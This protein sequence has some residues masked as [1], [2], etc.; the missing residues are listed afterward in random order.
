[1][2]EIRR[3]AGLRHPYLVPIIDYGVS[4]DTVYIAMPRLL[5][6]SLQE[7]L[8][9][10]RMQQ[11]LRRNEPL[12]VAGLPSLGEIAA[13]L[14]RI[15]AGLDYAHARQI[16]HQQVQP[17]NI[18]FDREGHAYLGD[19]GLT[20][21]F[22]V[23]FSLKETN[24][25]T[26]H[27]FSS[28]EQWQGETMSA[29]SDQYSL[30]AVVYLLVTGRLVFEANS[31]YGLMNMHMNDLLTPP[32]Q[33]RFGLPGDLTP[34]L[35]KALA[36]QPEIRYPNVTAFAQDFARSIQGLEGR[37]TDFFT[38]PLR[39]SS[40]RKH[41]VYLGSSEGDVEA[42]QKVTEALNSRGIT[43]WKDDSARIGSL[44][45]KTALVDA[46]RSAGVVVVVMS[47]GAMRSE[48]VTLALALAH[49]HRKPVIGFLLRG[50]EGHRAAFSRIIEAEADYNVALQTLIQAIQGHLG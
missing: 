29:E 33:V 9:R 38:F 32:H 1:M 45:W 10:R 20:K 30:A 26:T 3:V 42:A 16:I 6:G 35:L 11:G 23:I 49:K 27:A 17:G 7:R 21:L 31:I 39:E 12:D 48:W 18:L 36:K 5:G 44:S 8:L 28:P 13:M 24:A 19:A 41:D 22:K 2:E 43:T 4:G 40:T 46:V 34:V 47:P 15:A 37:P 25:V 50:S 14:E